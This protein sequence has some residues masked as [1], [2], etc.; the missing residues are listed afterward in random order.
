MIKKKKNKK[1]VIW[2]AMPK[3]NKRGQVFMIGIMMVVMALLIFIATLPATKSLINDVRGCSNL[4]CAGYVD[5]DASGGD[6]CIATNQT[7]VSTNE[8]D[9]LACTILD[10]TI[11]FLILGVLAAAVFKITRGEAIEQPQYGGGY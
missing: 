11:P 3:K 4:N 8:E 10:L 9:T 7:Y 6:A 5:A 1:P 2:F